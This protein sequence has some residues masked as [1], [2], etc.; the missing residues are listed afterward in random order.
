M[1]KSYN[2]YDMKQTNNGQMNQETLLMFHFVYQLQEEI[3]LRLIQKTQSIP[4]PK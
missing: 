2:Q 1:K 4:I 3:L